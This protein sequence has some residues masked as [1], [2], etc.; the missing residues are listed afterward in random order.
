MTS[1]LLSAAGQ[2]GVTTVADLLAASPQSINR[3]R[4]VAH[5][6]RRRLLEWRR[7][8]AERA[9]TTPD[10][11]EDS[12]GAGRSVDALTSQLIPV[13]TQAGTERN[14]VLRLVLGLDPLNSRPEDQGRDVHRWPTA[15]EVAEAAVTT[16]VVVAA[17]IAAARARWGKS[18]SVFTPLRAEVT[19]LLDAQGSVMTAKELAVAVLALRGSELRGEQRERSAA[20]VTRAAVEAADPDPSTTELSIRRLGSLVMVVAA[21]PGPADTVMAWVAALAEEADRLD[22]AERPLSG[23]PLVEALRLVLPADVSGRLSDGRV[24]SL[25][26]AASERTAL[27]AR[28]EL[29]PRGMDPGRAIRRAHGSLLGPYSLTVEE[30]QRRV[31][32]RYPEA[33]QLPGRPQ[34]DRLLSEAGL[35][36]EWDQEGQV[37]EVPTH[38]LAGISSATSVITDGSGV[39]RPQGADSGDAEAVAAFDRRLAASVADGG[40][41]AV[42]VPLRQVSAVTESLGNRGAVLFDVDRCLVRHLRAV[43]E[44]RR[45]PDFS[46]VV[47]ADGAPAGSTD[48]GRLRQLVDLA[49]PRL[50]AEIRAAGPTV[51]LGR[52]GLLARYGRL[53]VVEQL[54]DEAGTTTSPLR[55]LWVVVP[56]DTPG[57]PTLDGHP[58]P[59]LT[60]GQWVTVPPGWA[61][62]P[63]S[64]AA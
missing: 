28:L 56:G 6:S 33:A 30:V 26:T 11:D 23:G 7:V 1:R 37:Y 32:S 2:L 42:I 12:T 64:V 18:R 22:V 35:P 51:T 46:V 15:G 60:F 40:F 9:A 48:A 54:R 21:A 38:P 34:L 8:L 29:Y 43:A 47:A 3:L 63:P 17:H 27:S 20:A 5:Q 57:P 39:T 16:T 4:G 49:L 24:L 59:I 55:T 10:E 14:Q 13:T 61:Q 19:A 53:D 25:A 31:R 58:V 62:Q 52:F 45:I 36:L 41:L 44:E 50:V